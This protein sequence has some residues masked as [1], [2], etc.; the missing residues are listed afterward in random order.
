MFCK[1]CAINL[2]VHMY[3]TYGSRGILSL[4]SLKCSL[5]SLV[6][7]AV[8]AVC[9]CCRCILLWL[10]PRGAQVWFEHHLTSDQLL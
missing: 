10:T 7:D 9:S 6:F 4:A 5:M 8:D 3:N 1:R 2:S